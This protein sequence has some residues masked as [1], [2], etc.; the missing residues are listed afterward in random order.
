M[1]QKLGR[2]GA[3]KRRDFLRVI[4]ASGAVAGAA[5][6]AGCTVPAVRPAAP[7]ADTQ[8]DATAVLPTATPAAP[9]TPVAAA[10]SAVTPAASGRGRVALVKTDKRADGVRQALALFGVPDVEGKQLFLKANFNSA[11][12]TPGS[13]HPDVLRTLVAALQVGKPSHIVV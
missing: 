5:L 3:M 8:G 10:D 12:P 9:L 7:P 6:L 2:A 4:G 13:T 11:D 1:L